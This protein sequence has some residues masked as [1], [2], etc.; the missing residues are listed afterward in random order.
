MDGAT[1][2]STPKTPKQLLTVMIRLQDLDRQRDKNTNLIRTAGEMVKQ[3]QRDVE[4]RRADVKRAEEA[5]VNAKKTAAAVELELKSK[6]AN[7]QKL[8]MQQNTAKTNQE[9]QALASHIQRVR[10]E[11]AK[12]EDAG[13]AFYETITTCEKQLAAARKNAEDAETKAREFAIA[14][15]KDIE[16]A[17]REIGAT[18]DKRKALLSELPIETAEQY[19]KLRGAREGVAI[20]ALDGRSCGGCGVLATPNEVSKLVSA[21]SIVTCKSCQRILYS[22]AAIPY[23]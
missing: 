9:Y 3:R 4:A 10:Q 1:S 7:I 14:C 20:V 12:E 22:T 23:V 19:E 8:E 15:G 2:P 6:A 5:L 16:E 17:N 21:S 13:L 18:E 11:V